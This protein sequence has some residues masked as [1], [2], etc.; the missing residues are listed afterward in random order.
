MNIR[1]A[2]LYDI[3]TIAK[4]NVMLAKETENLTLN[5]DKA[6][7]GTREVFDKDKNRGFYLVMEEHENI[8]GQMLITYEWSDWR[9]QDIW[10][11]HRVYVVKKYRNNG[12]FTQMMQKLR[13]LAQQKQVYAIRLYVHENNTLAHTI[14]SANGFSEAPFII[15][16]N[17]LE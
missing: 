8:I 10:W 3:P 16:Q 12:V 17:L 6:L 11:V 14:Y 4:N 13:D 9:N 15:Y 2:K 5:E 1:Y 7:L